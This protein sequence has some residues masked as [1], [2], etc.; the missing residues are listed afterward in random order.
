MSLYEEEEVKV[1]VRTYKGSTTGKLYIV[2]ANG[3]E[4]PVE[5]WYD[6]IIV[7]G[8]A[9]NDDCHA[10]NIHPHGRL[11]DADAVTQK[12][13]D[14]CKRAFGTEEV[15]EYSSLSIVLDYIDAAPTVIQASE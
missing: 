5:N 14:N 13:W 9:K 7:P 2:R 12:V 8:W 15:P 11:I 6:E 10:E 4:Y 1:V 3:N